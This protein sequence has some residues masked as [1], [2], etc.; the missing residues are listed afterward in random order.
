MGH[1]DVVLKQMC[2]S[3]TRLKCQE[4]EVFRAVGLCYTPIVFGACHRSP[5]LRQAH[6]GLRVRLLAPRGK[7]RQRRCCPG[8]ICGE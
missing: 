5:E 6:H 4:C 7:V 8:R 3:T 2:P 1:T